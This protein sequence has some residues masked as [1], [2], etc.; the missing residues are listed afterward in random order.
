MPMPLEGPATSPGLESPQPL[1]RPRTQAPRVPKLLGSLHILHSL[2]T[3]HVP[4]RTPNVHQPATLSLN[5]PPKYIY[6]W[7]PSQPL[8][9]FQH[10]LLHTPSPVPNIHECPPP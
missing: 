6:P 7:T 2:Y 10:K 5:T 8:L 4:L 1:H 9:N 3:L